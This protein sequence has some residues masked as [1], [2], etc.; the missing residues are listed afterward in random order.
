MDILVEIICYIFYI[1]IGTILIRWY[2]YKKGWEKSLDTSLLFTLC[3]KI[4]ILFLMMGLTL[5]IEFFL[6]IDFSNPFQSYGISLILMLISFTLNILLGLI[7]FRSVFKQNIHESIVIIL[8]I[9]IIELIIENIV[10]YFVM[11]PLVLI[12]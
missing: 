9:V 5:L 3:W 7:L 4:I 12:S 10:L 2:T 6:G 11:F 1:I 8:T